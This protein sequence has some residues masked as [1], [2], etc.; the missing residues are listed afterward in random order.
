MQAF[1]S[2]P[3]LF[4]MRKRTQGAIQDPP[5]EKWTL[6]LNNSEIKQWFKTFALVQRPLLFSRETIKI[7]GVARVRLLIPARDLP[8]FKRRLSS[9][10]VGAP[11]GSE[12]AAV[13]ES[14]D[15]LRSL[16]EVR[17]CRSSLSLHPMNREVVIKVTS[18]DREQ[19]SSLGSQSGPVE[20]ISQEWV[21]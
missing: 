10:A 17:H 14:I 16:P 2:L 12:H 7:R 6:L 19:E 15:C 3:F 4:R 9:G 8:S 21:T 5:W 18:Q 20:R 13:R 1:S 11:Q